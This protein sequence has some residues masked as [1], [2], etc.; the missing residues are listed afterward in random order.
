MLIICP[1]CSSEYALATDRIGATGRVVRCAACR[2]VWFVQ[3]VETAETADSEVE[4]AD[5]AAAPPGRFG[6]GKTAPVPARRSGRLPLALTLGLAAALGLSVAMREPI[7]R[8][9]PESAAAFAALGLP[10]NLVGL[11][12][13]AVS[14]EL[15]EEANGRVLLISGEIVNGGSHPLPVPP[16]A[17]TIEGEAG[18]LL[19]NWSD[20]T[21]RGEIAPHEAKRFQAKLS[22]PPPDGRRV[23]VSFST[24]AAAP[25]VAS[26]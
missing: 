6:R 21:D 18:E 13:G 24:K 9:V 26:R 25:A 8:H 17:L 14:S 7:V 20:R 15:A 5:S 1:T 19:Y 10:V 11:Q 3:P 12:L 23:L 4:H 2:S 16:L 22:S